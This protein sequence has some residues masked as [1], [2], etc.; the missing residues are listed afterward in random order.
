MGTVTC[1]KLHEEAKFMKGVEQTKFSWPVG[2]CVRAAWATI[3]GLPF[4]EVP[5]FSP[6]V[7]GSGSDQLQMEREWIRTLG[8][9]LVVVPAGSDPVDVP[10]DVCHLISG[11]SPRGFG[12]RCVGRGGKLVWD[13]HPSHLGLDELWSYTFLVP[14]DVRIETKQQQG[15]ELLG[16]SGWI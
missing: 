16:F 12:H 1:A 6:G 15:R 11:L 8:F 10:D 13:P 7:L 9:D 14:L 4:E 2:D 5:D 3:L